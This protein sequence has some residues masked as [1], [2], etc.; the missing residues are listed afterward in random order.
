[1]LQR[2]KTHISYANIVA[3]LALFVALGGTG[4]AAFS[5]PKDSVGARE[6]RNRA[7]GTAELQAGSVT[8]SKVRDG[9]LGLRDL[10]ETA[11]TAL[12]G[13]QGP[14]GP[15]GGKGDV[16]PQGPLGP[17][18][19]SAISE[20]VVVN[21]V[22]SKTGGTATSVTSTGIGVTVVRFGRSVA[23][24]ASNATVAR[25]GG[26]PDPAAGRVTVQ[27]TTDGAVL[28]RT[29]NAAGAPGDLGF[30]LIVVCS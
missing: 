30:H 9:S 23:A 15:P 6:L 13:P 12:T 7:V 22:P 2:L 1:M 24:C 19:A 20:W 21:G 11:R 29:Y 5:L 3:T 25:V 27:H 4:Y 26:D 8:S 14:Q 18:G 17:A 10:T 16:G 28:V